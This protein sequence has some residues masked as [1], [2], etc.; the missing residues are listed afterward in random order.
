M[1]GTLYLVPEKGETQKIKATLKETSYVCPDI[2]SSIHAGD[3]WVEWDGNRLGLG[4]SFGAM[5]MNGEWALAVALEICRHFK[6]KKAGWDS[7]GYCKNME[8]FMRSVPMKRAFVLNPFFKRRY[9]K[10]YEEQA[11]KIFDK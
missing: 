5:M 1:G 7:V 11:R 9:R 8:E 4:Y 2:K 3:F 10:W 6:I